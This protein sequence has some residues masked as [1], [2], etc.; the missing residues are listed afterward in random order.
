ME[1]QKVKALE[2]W[3]PQILGFAN[4]YCRFIHN[5]GIVAAL[6]TALT[7]LKVKFVWSPAADKAFKDLKRLFTSASI[8]CQPDPSRQFIVETSASE[9]GAGAMLSERCMR[10]GKVH[11]CSY[12][13]YEF[14]STETN[15]SIGDPELLAIKLT[16]EEWRHWLKGATSPFLVWTDHK[17]LEFIRFAK[18]QN[19]RQALWSLFCNCSHWLTDSA[20]SM[21]NL[22][23]SPDSSCGQEGD[24]W[25]HHPPKAML[26]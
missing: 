21:G 17:K 1:S 4:F 25:D 5:F 9:L 14:S 22:M 11:A 7:S 12:F 6:L 19:S 16:L 15:C 20:P 26:G 23:P 3:Q 10:N 2:N 8:L 18:C 24:R 13:S